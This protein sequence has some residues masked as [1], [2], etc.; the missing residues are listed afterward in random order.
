MSLIET[1]Q[2]NQGFGHG[3]FSPKA[4]MT[5]HGVI[6]AAVEGNKDARH[7][8]S[9]RDAKDG[10]SVANDGKFRIGYEEYKDDK[11]K[12]HDIIQNGVVLR[13]MICPIGDI[14][15]KDRYEAKLS[16]DQVR[17]FKEGEEMKARER[18]SSAEFN[19]KDETL[20]LTQ[21]T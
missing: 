9:V 3:V 6:W 17:D 1:K 5:R 11:G 10:I 14:Q 16:S 20:A 12:T 15:A 7:F 21:P 19:T 18:G 4:D 2:N 8:P 13:E